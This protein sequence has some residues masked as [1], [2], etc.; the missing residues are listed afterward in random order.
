MIL[1]CRT[2]GKEMKLLESTWINSYNS[3]NGEREKSV[4]MRLYQCPTVGVNQLLHFSRKHDWAETSMEEGKDEVL[5]F[6]NAEE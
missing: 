5:N 3:F 1:F 4:L 2:C 6:L